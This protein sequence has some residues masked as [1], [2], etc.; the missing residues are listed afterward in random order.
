MEIINI[1]KYL[2]KN[3]YLKI[4][5]N[6]NEKDKFY[7]F[8]KLTLEQFKNLNKKKIEFVIKIILNKIIY[9]EGNIHNECLKTLY[10]NIQD[11]KSINLVILNKFISNY[12]KLKQLNIIFISLNYQLINLFKKKFKEFNYFS[13]TKSLSLEDQINIKL[14]IENKVLIYYN[15][16][17]ELT[18]NNIFFKR[19]SDCK[20]L[21]TQDINSN[22]MIDRLICLK[23]LF[24]LQFL[25][26][27]GIEII[28][29]DDFL[30]MEYNKRVLYF[31]NFYIK[32]QS[33]FKNYFKLFD[34][35]ESIKKEIDEIINIDP[36]NYIDSIYDSSSSFFSEDNLEIEMSKFDENQKISIFEFDNSYE[37][38]EY[39]N[40]SSDEENRADTPFVSVNDTNSDNESN[41]SNDEEN[42]SDSESYGSDSNS[43]EDEINDIFV[44]ND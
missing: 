12:D 35:I 19:I 41:T 16:F 28:S 8:I 30:N 5:N 43:D 21:I 34:A 20:N 2:D 7:N 31:R 22:E 15:S 25:E 36:L 39:E 4:L 18:Y 44:K 23:K 37:E 13:T 33:I 24:T 42:D 9:F 27:L 38:I 26:K 3:S 10:E 1:S 11:E 17:F 6:L 29:V 32:T 40:S 14:L